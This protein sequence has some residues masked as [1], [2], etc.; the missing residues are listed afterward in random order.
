MAATATHR[1]PAAARGGWTNGSTT[2]AARRLIPAGQSDA[3]AADAAPVL[4]LAGIG[5]TTL[6][7]PLAPIFVLGLLDLTVL[8]RATPHVCR[9]FDSRLAMAIR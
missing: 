2:S 3:E 6:V 7:I 4:D 9:G 5:R 1:R 8:D